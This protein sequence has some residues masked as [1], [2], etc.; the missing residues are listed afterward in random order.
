MNGFGADATAVLP[1]FQRIV[2]DEAH[3]IER[4][5]LSYFSAEYSRPQL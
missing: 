3:H 2:F 1:P 4:A 5:L